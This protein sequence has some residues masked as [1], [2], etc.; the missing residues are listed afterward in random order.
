MNL[1]KKIFALLTPKQMRIC[2]LL[3][4]LMFFIA[5][6]EALGIGL[7]YP[8]I[9]MMGDPNYLEN[10][11]FI[12]KMAMFFGIHT[13]KALVIIATGS[14]L[15]FYILKNLLI[16]LQGKL[17]ISFSLN[18]QADYT[19]RLYALYMQKPYLFHVN[20]NFAEIGRNISL[21]CIIAFS[22]VLTNILI[23]ITNL[24]TMLAI[25]VFLL[26]IDW[27]MALVVV[28]VIGPLMLIIL[29]FF[30][31][32]ISYYGNIQNEYN[33]ENTKWI[34]QGFWSVKETKV[35]QKEDFFTKQFSKTFSKFVESQKQFLY[36]NRFPKCIIE[37][38]SVGG[39]LL[40]IIFKMLLN[41]DPTTIIPSLGVLAL[42]A[43]RL[44]P[45]MNQITG[46]YNQIKFRIPLIDEVYDDFMIIKKQKDLEETK[47]EIKKYEKLHFNNEIKVKDLT[48]AYPDVSKPVFSKVSF[49]I[50][51]GKFV[52]IVGPSGSGKTT[53]VDLLLGLLKP[54]SGTILV[55]GKNIFE[56]IN[57]WLDNV[58]Y[59][60]QSIYLIDGTIRENIAFGVLPEDIDDKKIEKV[61][62]MAELYDFV[63][64][65]D[66][67]ENT[68]CGDKGAKLSGGQ[69][70]RIGIARALYQDPT[71]LVLDEATSA[72]EKKKKKQITET[73]NKLKGEL[74]IIAIAHRLSTLESCDFK[75]KF[76]NGTIQQI[77]KE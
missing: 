35:M 13:H 59:V 14:I 16:L 63:Q 34:N 46:L 2:I 5:I 39:I 62:K 32:R 54:E 72:L 8:L 1:I 3:I 18:N 41:S 57:G 56:N 65:L 23:I 27:L 74:T 15:L 19:K 11:S 76:E 38:V 60:P 75:I 47:T 61:L 12:S 48:F 45:C 10:G 67:K 9:T 4:I 43:M 6:F 69:K 52:G 71:V 24:I 31:K 58:S 20:T 53:F 70:Q 55:D 7:I 42:A 68:P 40:L 33:V 66:L 25:W 37:L 17:Q 44:M 26:V 73:I 22:E 77:E 50:P 36:I 28:G 29:N 49:T 64:T 51:K 21:S 30:R